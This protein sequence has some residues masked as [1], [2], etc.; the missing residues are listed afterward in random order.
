MI[1]DTYD[2][3]DYM[4]EDSIYGESELFCIDAT[5]P[6]SIQLNF[7]A[8][9]THHLQFWGQLVTTY[10]WPLYKAKV[11]LIEVNCTLDTFH[12]N[13]L[14]ESL[15]DSSGFYHFEHLTPWIYCYYIKVVSSN[16][17]YNQLL[18]STINRCTHKLCTDCPCYLAL[19]KGGV[20]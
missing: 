14:G 20:Y 4:I 12:F 13:K 3:T 19:Q 2:L 9:C 6:P 16:I 7:M 10:Q 5:T 11:E 8:S 1:A 15:T 18:P 17:L